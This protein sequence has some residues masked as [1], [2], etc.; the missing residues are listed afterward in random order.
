MKKI[1]AIL[2]IV[3]VA[4]H[5]QAKKTTVTSAS[6]IN[7]GSWTA[8]DTIVLKNGIWNNQSISFVANGT[9]T[10]PVVLIPETEGAVILTG[11]SQLAFSGSYIII[12]GLYFK[13]GTLSGSDVISFKTSSSETANHCTL[14]NTAITNYNP[15]D[16][17]VDS[18][19]VSLYGTYN[20]VDHCSFENKTNSGT[21]LV[22]WLTSGNA[23]NHTISNN[24]FGYRNANV[25][26][27]GEELNGQ[28]IIRVGDSSTSMTTANVTVSGNFFEKCN[29]EIEVV[30]NK[31]CGNLYNNNLF[32]ECKGMLTLRHGNSC[33]VSGNYFFGNGISET[34]GVRIIGENH[35]VYNNYFENLRG[36]NYRA[37]LCIVRGKENSALSEYFQVKNA[38]VAYNTFVN[39]TQTFCINYNSSS[40][41]TM[42]PISTTIAHNHIYNLSTYNNVTVD[43]TSVSNMDVT[44]KNNIMNKGSYTDFTYN[45]TQII[46]GK[47]A[48]MSIVSTSTTMY[49]PGTSSALKNYTT[50]EY[51]E[52]SSD[53]RGRDRGTTA[54]IPGASQLSGTVLIAMPIKSET[55]APFINAAATGYVSPNNTAEAINFAIDNKTLKII[56]KNSGFI[57]IYNYKGLLIKQYKITPNCT[58]SIEL[59]RGIY[60]V[61]YSQI[62]GMKYNHKIMIN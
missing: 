47:D 45:S 38:L 58:L 24:Y 42:P 43:Q 1:T 33:T 59:S 36:T 3:F 4:F 15:S 30:S 8:G 5:V 40:T 22:V 49:E 37:A 29:G 31:S 56:G 50:T 16:K 54:K 7:N 34:G 27:N 51:A 35:K 23:A 57:E 14:K 2:F 41:L 44:W 17:T 28:E 18:K 6:A 53:I 11:S 12:S 48:K 39:C 13:D 25:D 61:S 52:I 9:A 10:K 21:L 62:N 26:E 20:T 46:T 32:M 19:W 55:G 60:I